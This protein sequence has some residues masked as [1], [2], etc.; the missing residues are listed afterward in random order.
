MGWQLSTDVE[1]FRRAAHPYLLRDPGRCTLLLTISESVRSGGRDGS[2][3][4]GWWRENERAA[5]AGAFVQTP[6]R[7]PLLGP[8]P[9]EAARA[10]AR[11][12]RASDPELPGAQGVQGETSCAEA[13]AAEWTGRSAGWSVATE[14]RLLRL[15]E[16]RPPNPAPQGRARRAA[17]ADVPLVAEW[18]SA[19]AVQLGDHGAESDWVRE[20]RRRVS[21]GALLLWEV[22]GA[23]VSMAGVSPVV[24]GHAR[25][26][27]VY[28][29][30]ACRGRGYAAGVTAAVSQAALAAGA[31]QV[32]LFVDALNATAGALY[33]RLGYDLVEEQ[34]ALR[35]ES[36]QLRP[37][38]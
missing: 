10:L 38:D 37:A 22:E 5:V 14:T 15:G 23:P 26:A 24:L 2:V 25:V 16:S 3:R 17:D 30:P 34:R 8:M 11:T 29:P 33:A 28:T 35:W 7:R 12:L 27:P 21:T 36:G 13:F 1:E 9:R 32:L 18:L 31:E 6:P 4:F 20:A 19:F